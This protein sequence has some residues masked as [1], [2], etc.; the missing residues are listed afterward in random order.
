M[1]DATEGPCWLA[2]LPPLAPDCTLGDVAAAAPAVCGGRAGAGAGFGEEV[3][4]A[5]A[6]NVATA[7]NERAARMSVE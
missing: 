5:E 4:H 2:A 7:P 1:L 3:E 6:S